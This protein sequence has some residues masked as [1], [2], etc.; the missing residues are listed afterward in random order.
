MILNKGKQERSIIIA[1]RWVLKLP[2]TDGLVYLTRIGA[3]VSHIRLVSKGKK[4]VYLISVCVCVCLPWDIMSI[5]RDI[6]FLVHVLSC[7]DV[8]LLATHAKIKVHTVG[9]M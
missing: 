3:Q 7:H 5:D 8:N 6:G 9:R 2:T 1:P 4:I